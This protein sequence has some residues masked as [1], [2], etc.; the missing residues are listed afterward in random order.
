LPVS[1]DKETIHPEDFGADMELPSADS[2]HEKIHN[3]AMI[4][5][6]L[7][8]FGVGPQDCFCEI[9]FG[10]AAFRRAFLGMSG[11]NEVLRSSR[12]RLEK[13]GG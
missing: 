2:L 12:A 1:G 5:T 7:F 13:M 6:A 4:T 11:D 3:S 8:S 9:G 10:D